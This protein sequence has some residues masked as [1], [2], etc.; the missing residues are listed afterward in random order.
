MDISVVVA[1]RNEI[2]YIE[3]CIES[4]FK[5]DFDGEYEVIVV[6]GMSDDGTYEM[7]EKLQ[8]KYKFILL[9]NPKK[10]AAAGRNIGIDAAKGDAIAFIDGDAIAAKNWLSSIKKAF[11]K[12]NAIGVGG[13]DL[14][15]EDSEYKARAIGLV[16]TSPLAR[17]GRFNPSTQHA[18]MEKERY[19]EHIPTCNLCLKKEIFDE[20]GKFDENFV[21]G[22][23]LELNYRIV[24]AGYKL[25]YSPSIQVTHYRKQHIRH[26]ARQIYKWAKAKAAI[27]K[28]HGMQGIT[29]HIYLWPAYAILV[30]LFS[31]ILFLVLNIMDIFVALF[32]VAL[33][34]YVTTILLESGRLSRRYRDRKLFLYALVLLLVVHL[35]YTYGVVIALIRR[36]IW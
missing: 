8:K 12:S 36:K 9:K 5:Q 30:F 31:F 29:S 3:K 34:S 23:D 13:P 28:K 32:F 14:L 22:Q 4:L 16:M 17:G 27:I 1:V 2:N 26:F 33:I 21:K 15:P 7:L 19:V 25:F 24:K 10:N 11:E 6:D 20:V 18:M 35:S